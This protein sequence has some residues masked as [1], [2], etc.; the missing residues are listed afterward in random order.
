M[1][2]SMKKV[3]YVHKLCA[4]AVCLL[5][6]CSIQATDQQ[7]VLTASPCTWASSVLI[8]PQL[9]ESSFS[10]WASWDCTENASV[11]ASGSWCLLGEAL[12]GS[13]V[14]PKSAAPLDTSLS[15]LQSTSPQTRG[16]RKK[17]LG[18]LN[19]GHGKNKK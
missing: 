5:Q 14:G 11:S 19:Q 16:R 7:G 2:D 10:G 12:P 17:N 8:S 3:D 9:I 15:S 18:A 1:L 6:W 4:G 13:L